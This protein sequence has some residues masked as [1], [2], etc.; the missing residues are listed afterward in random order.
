MEEKKQAKSTTTTG[1][2]ERGEE[3]K[4]A[5]KSGERREGNSWG[6]YPLQTSENS[7]LYGVGGETP[8]ETGFRSRS[9]KRPSDEGN[10]I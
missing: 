10:L 2:K 3:G 6:A 5:L 7:R 4:E 8:R 9:A 1:R